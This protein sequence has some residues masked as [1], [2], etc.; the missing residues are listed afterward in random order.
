MK[1][2]YIE[3]NMGAAGDMLTAA[4]LELHPDK[5]SF[6]R[7]MN[8]LRLP[9][10]RITAEKSIKCGITGTHVSVT[11]N[12]EEEES[13]DVDN[14]CCERM[15]SEAAEVHRHEHGEHSHTHDHVHDCGHGHGEAGEHHHDHTWGHDHDNDCGHEH[16]H[17]QNH[18]DDHAAHNHSGGHDEGSA[19]CHGEQDHIHKHDHVGHGHHHH[20]GMHEIGHIIAALELPQKVKEDALAVYGLIAEAESHAHD[21]PVEEVHFHEVGALD[22]VADVVGVCLLIHELAPERIVVS[23]VH[24][25]SGQVR[26]AHGILPV[27]APATAYILKGVPTYGGRVAGELCTPTGAALLKH[28]A[29]RFAPMP[30]MRVGQIGYGMGTK[31]FEQANCIRVMLGETE[32]GS[33]SI[34][35][36]CCNLDDMTPEAVG[37]AVELLMERGALDVYTTAVQMKKNRPGILLTCMCREEQRETMLRL[38]FQHTSTLGIRESVCNRYTLERKESK[39]QTDWGE[40]RMKESS[41]WG[42][43]KEKAEYDDLVRIAKEKGISL[44]DAADCIRRY[45]DK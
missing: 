30:V 43:H 10:V 44:S 22:A 4:L 24:T 16:S 32:E 12:G 42:V 18:D 35:E 36:L 11:V 20:S 13:L 33:E 29:D 3:C 31:D 41:G 14:R 21:K 45:A 15:S 23:P 40:V 5:D 25:G 28:F 27:P 19:H 17:G 7:K 34:V 38:I 8:E 37:F 9:G 2:L 6:L 1:T 39:V 26:C